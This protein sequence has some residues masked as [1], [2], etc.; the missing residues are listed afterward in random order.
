MKKLLLAA[1]VL[2]FAASYTLAQ[3]NG[4]G[5]KSATASVELL[6]EKWENRKELNPS[7][8]IQDL[9]NPMDVFKGFIKS[10]NTETAYYMAVEL[11]KPFKAGWSV[12]GNTIAV[13]TVIKDFACNVV[14]GNVQTELDTFSCYL[15]KANENAKF[16]EQVFDG[17]PS[18]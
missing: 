3:Q 6:R 5:H 7:F 4:A 13:L 12:N 8:L 9:M 17:C 14:W 11:N 1:C 16:S 2:F 18:F 10:G 15:K